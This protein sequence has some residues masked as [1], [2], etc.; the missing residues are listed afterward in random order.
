[1]SPTVIAESIV[2]LAAIYV[3]CGIVFALAFLAVGI[4]RL[5]PAAD[6][7]GYGFRALIFPGTVALWPVLAR[8]WL[9]GGSRPAERNAHR[10][11]AGLEGSR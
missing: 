9:G 8:R 2:T 5:D 10:D 3:A 11:A 4:G 1:M 7:S 6:G